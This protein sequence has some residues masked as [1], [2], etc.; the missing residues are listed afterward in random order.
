[1]AKDHKFIEGTPEPK[2]Q[3]SGGSLTNMPTQ[4]E[5]AAWNRDVK[6]KIQ[7]GVKKTWEQ[8]KQFQR[9]LNDKVL[10]KDTMY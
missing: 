5:L 7:A 6:P 9:K 1:M 10:L 3:A 4:A 8:I 2:Q